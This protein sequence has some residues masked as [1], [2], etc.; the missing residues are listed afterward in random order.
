MSGSKT[1]KTLNPAAVKV[2][3]VN[4]N[5]AVPASDD[6]RHKR[7]NNKDLYDELD[8]PAAVKQTVTILEEKS[9][10]TLT[11]IK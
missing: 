6:R 9:E 4:T 2:E 8:F 7:L 5:A 11:S 1:V 10:R 3:G